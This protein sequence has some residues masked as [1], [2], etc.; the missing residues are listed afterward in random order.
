MLGKGEGKIINTASMA[1]L[2][3]PHPQQQTAYNASKAAGGLVNKSACLLRWQQA[4][5]V[6]WRL[7]ACREDNLKGVCVPPPVGPTPHD[8]SSAVFA[9]NV[10]HT[11]A[12]C[13]QW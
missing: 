2:L 3:V 11:V 6:P 5:A 13:L 12:V 8:L 1:S 4:K 9:C 7:K 10:L